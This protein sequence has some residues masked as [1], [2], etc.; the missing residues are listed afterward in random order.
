[1]AVVAR[2]FETLCYGVGIELIA[3]IVLCYALGEASTF[4][5]LSSVFVANS[6]YLDSGTLLHS[7]VLGPLTAYVID[8]VTHFFSWVADRLSNVSNLLVQVMQALSL[9]TGVFLQKLCIALISIPLFAVL[10]DIGGLDGFVQ[11]ELRRY[12]VGIESTKREHFQRLVKWC[13]RAA[14]IGYVAIP[15]Y[16]PAPIWFAAWGVLAA[17]LVQIQISFIQKYI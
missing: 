7:F 8:P 3:A 13:V 4:N 10:M 5:H 2:A 1:M 12:R 9:A 6:V 11:R 14:F 15:L 16:L 17:W